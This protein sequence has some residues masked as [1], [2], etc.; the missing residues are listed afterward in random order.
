MS[1]SSP[2]A[3]NFSTHIIRTVKGLPEP[4]SIDCGLGSESNAPEI[5]GLDG[6]WV[7]KG[8]SIIALSGM[9]VRISDE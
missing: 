1:L 4:L 6:G 7:N 9:P 8:I 3:V 5:S 2:N